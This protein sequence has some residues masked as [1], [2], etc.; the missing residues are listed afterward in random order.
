M[1]PRTKLVLKLAVVTLA[2]TAAL[3]PPLPRSA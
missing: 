2:Q 1:P 3:Q